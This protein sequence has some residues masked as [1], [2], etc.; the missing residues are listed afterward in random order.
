MFWQQNLE[1]LAARLRGHDLPL[2]VCLWDGRSVDLGRT[3]NVV[4]RVNDPTGLRDLLRARLDV[5]GRAYVEG[6]LDVD[7]DLAEVIEV[8]AGLERH[9]AGEAWW[10]GRLVGAVR[11]TRA[12]DAEA[13]AYHYDVSNQFYRHWLDER[14]VYSC[15]YFEDE[16]DSLEEAQ[17]RK[18]DYVLR[19]IRLREGDRLLD[20]GCGWG[21]LILR[22]AQVYGARATGITLSKN[23]YELAQERITAAGLGDRCR[24]LLADFRDVVGSYDRITSIGM[25]EHVG[26]KNLRS[27]FAKVQALLADGGVAMNHGIT[28]TDPDSTPPSRRDSF[29]ARYVFPHGELPHI[30]LA[31]REM[32]AAGLEPVDVESLRRHYAV[33]LRHWAQRFEAAAGRIRAEVGEKHYRI[34]RIYLAGC[35]YAFDHN[36]TTV[37]QVLA[38]KAGGPGANPL[39]RTRD[40]MYG[41]PEWF[42]GDHEMPARASGPAATA[43]RPRGIV[44]D[45]DV[46]LGAKHEQEDRY[47]FTE[48]LKTDRG[49]DDGSGGA[50]F[51]QRP[52]A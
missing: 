44:E 30:G 20:I 19:K 42:A 37:H 49:R 36:W 6:R 4:M 24:V 15:A 46:G 2:R 45:P 9:A 8:A 47:S 18:I 35:A 34:W 48:I 51:R 1:W 26:L 40:Y 43:S 29:I 41:L 16:R 33:T 25:F 28:S 50:R 11:H 39:P 12:M 52:A 10:L 38:V 27:Y 5:L 13:I 14:M 21:A 7:G 23:Q 3:P 32:C 22:A 17:L 31:L